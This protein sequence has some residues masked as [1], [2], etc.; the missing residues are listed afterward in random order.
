MTNLNF[1]SQNRGSLAA[2]QSNDVGYDCRLTVVRPSFDCRSTLLKLV[3]VLVLVLTVGVGQMLGT[4]VSDSYTFAGSS[5]TG[6]SCSPRSTYCGLY[7]SGGKSNDFA[8]YNNSIANISGVDFSAVS[9]ASITIRVKGITNGGTNSFT[10]S[11]VNSSGTA[12]VTSSAQT[13]QFANSSNSSSATWS[14]NV[15]LTPVAGVTGYKINCKAKS[16]LAG[17]DYSLTYTAAV[18]SAPTVG[19]AL[20]SVSATTNSITATVPISATGGCNIT[21]NGL[22]YSSSN[23]TPTVGGTNCTKVTTTACGAT[24][25][26]KE[27]TITGLTCGT[28]YNI[29]GYATNSSGTTY[30][31]VLTQVTS[32]CPL[33]TVTLMDDSDTRT[34]G[35]YGAAVTLPSRAGCE[36]Y[37]FAGWTKSWVA[38]QTE[39]TATAPTVIP[40]GSYT[41]E[42]NENLYPVYTKTE[43]GSGFSSYTKVTSAPSD[44]SGKYLISDGTSTATGAQFSAS[45][46]EITTLTP[47]TTEYT[48]YEFTITKNGNNNNYYIISPD[49]TY[50]VGYN[51]STNLQFSTST[52]A[53]NSYLWTCQTSDPMTLN[54]ATNTRYIGVGTESSTSVFKAYSTSGSNAKCY[55]Y[56]RI[57]GGSTTYYK[58]VPNCCTALGQINGS[59]SWSNSGTSLTVKNWGYTPANTG[60]ES[61]IS[62]YTVYLYSDEDS[63]TDPI[64]G[65]GLDCTVANRASTGVTFTGLDYARTY[66]VKITVTP[67]DGYCPVDEAWSGTHMLTCATPTATASSFARATQKMPI[68]WTSGAEKVDICYSSNSYTPG[69]TPGEGYTTVSNQT[70]SP[71]NLDVSGLAAGNY[72]C[73]VRSVCDASNKSD[74]TAITG[75]TFTIPAHTLTI[76]KDG[77]GS[78]TITPASG[79]S[80]VE[81]RT[82]SIEA[83]PANGYAFD[84]WAVSGTN[85]S[86]SSTS[87]NPTTFT[88][89]TANATVTGYFTCVTPAFAENGHPVSKTDYLTTDVATALSYT[90]SAAGATLTQQWQVST[91]N[92]SW[93]DIAALSGGTAATYTPDISTEGTKYYRVIVTNSAAGCSS[94]TATSNVA[95][96]RSTAPSGYCISVYNSSNNGIQSGFSNGGLGNEYTLAF[97]VPGKDGSS[98]WPMFWIGENNSSQSYSNNDYLANM[99]FTH[100]NAT[101]G[102]AEGATGTLHIWD[103]NKEAGSNLWV[104]F[105]PD[106]YGLRWGGADW[107][108][109]ENTKA[110]TVDPG[111]ANVWWTDLVTLDG[112]NNTTWNYYVGLKT[113]SGYVYSGV[114]NEASDSRGLSRTRSVTAMKVSN[115]TSGSFKATYLDGESTGTR[116]KFRIWDN[117]IDDY[118]FVCHFV[119]FWQLQ[120]N[121]NGGEGNMSPLPATPVCCEASSGSR[122]VTVATSSFTAPQYKQFDHWN[123]AADNSGSNVNTGSYTLTGDVTLYAQWS[124]IP[125]T[126]LTL[127]NSSLTKYVGES[128]VTLSVTDVTPAAANPAVT[129]SSSDATVAEVTAGGVVSFLKA[130]TATI[131]A[132]STVSGGVTATC[133]VVVRS[134]SGPT[135]KDTDGTTISGSGLSATWTVGT[136]TL[137]AS[138]ETSNYKFKRWV[139]T[140]ATPASE[141]NATTTLGDPTGNVTVVA[142]FYKPITVAWKVGNGNASGS[143]TTEVK[144]G[145]AITALPN[146][147]ADD[148]IASCGANK[149]MGWTA[150]G[151]LEGTGHSAPADLFTTVGGATTLTTNTT[152]RAVFATQSSGGAAVNTVLWEEDFSAWGDGDVPDA[153][154]ITNSHTGT[155]VYGD[156]TLTYACV[157]GGS[158]TRLYGGNQ[159]LYAGGTKPELLV[160]KNTGSFTVSGIPNGGASEITVSYKQNNKSLTVSASGTGYSGDN[161]ANTTATQSFDVT[162]GSASTFTLTF[163][164]TQNE[165]ARLDDISVKVKTAG[166]SI[167]NYITGCCTHLDDLNGEVNW[168]NPTTAVVSWDNIGHVSSWTVKY[169]TH[170]AGAYT[171]WDGSQTVYTKS[172]SNDSRKVTITGLTPCVDY[173]FKIM[174][175]ADEDYCDKDQTIEDD[176]A[177]AYTVDYSGCSNVTKTGGGTTACGSSNLVATFTA[178]LPYELPTSVSVSIGGTPQTQGTD[179]T[180]S[181]AAGVGTLTIGS[182]KQTANI[183][184]DVDGNLLT[185]DVNPTI[186]TATLDGSGTFNLSSVAVSV[187]GCDVGSAVCAWA[188]YGFVWGTSANPTGNKTA[189]G[190]DGTATSWSG[191]LTGSFSTGVTYYYRAYG[192]NSKDGAAIVYGSDATF[193]PRSVTFNVNGGS[194]VAAKYVNNGGTVSAPSDP[195]KNGYT[196]GGWYTDNGTWASPVNWSSTISANVTYY[197]KWNT[198]PYTITYDG[199]SGASNTNPTEYNIETPTI[200]LADPG[201]RTGYTFDRWTC[202]GD[203]ITQI[204]QGSTGDKT[205]TANWSIHTPNLAVSAP[206][207]VA[208]TATPA[209]ELAIEEGANRNVNY[210]KTITLNC[211]PDDHWNLVWDVYKT[212]S[213]PKESISLTGS[214]DGATF[215]M[216]D[217]AVTVSAVMTEDTY[218]TA[219]FMNNA[220]VI[221]GYGAVKTYDG[222]RPTPP[223]L[224]DVTD[225]CDKTECNK[226]YG[227]IAEGDIWAKTIPSVAGKTIYRH[228]EDIPVVSG[229]NVVYHA[230][231]AKGSGDPDMPNTLIAKWDKQSIAASTAIK[232]KDKDGNTLN[233]VTMTSNVAMTTDGVYCY[234]N[235]S[236]STDPVITLAGLDFSDYNAG[237]I[238]FFMRGSQ[239]PLVTVDY[240]TNGGSTYTTDYFSEGTAK[241]EHGYVVTVPNTTTN[242][243]ISYGSNT[244]NLYFGTVRA[245]GT[246]TTSY[247]FTELTSSNTSGW[248]GAD[249]DGYYLIVG[250]SSTKALRSD[251]MEGLDGLT[252][253]SASEGVIS[254]SD[255]GLMFKAKYNSVTSK[256]AI[257]SVATQDYLTDAAG[258]ASDPFHL[259]KTSA[260]EVVSIAYNDILNAT[261]YYVRWNSD[262]FGSYGSCTAPTLYKIMGSFSEFRVTCCDKE[263]TIGTPTKTGSGTVTFESGGDAYDVGDKVETCEGETTITATVTPANGF[264]CTALGFSGGSVSVSPAIPE[265]FV[266]YTAATAYTL[267]FDQNTDATLATTVTFTALVDN[268]ID[269]MHYNAT[270]EKSGDYGTVPSLSSETKGEDVC[271]ESHYK[272]MGWVAEDEINADGSLKSGYTLISGGATGK[273]A[274]GTNYYAVW[275]E[276]AE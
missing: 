43:A 104:K 109:A 127:N 9:S 52:P 225:A 139:V 41:P 205:I 84:H 82:A 202:G 230:V 188:D 195:S 17:T 86:L 79:S 223:T 140:N 103:N 165:N 96:I 16:A 150:N 20:T 64:G 88:M 259:L 258:G 183:V 133:S 250:N 144:Y 262:R 261:G 145:T 275:A 177:H 137:T 78:S 176:Q 3:T 61:H 55:L 270:V 224:T 22:V 68:S 234:M 51:S 5:V 209:S 80:V 199:L 24:A 240:S 208:I 71:V 107:S 146:T 198:I 228:A 57:E 98:N 101:L 126:S 36:G 58:S 136:R 211:T 120:Y 31:N 131:T 29:R 91:D 49:G 189:I 113:A 214:G 70:S 45:A 236:I 272:F 166:T 62:K 167:S 75:N 115:G 179:F 274:T 161:T 271:S 153:D 182:A 184:I 72:Y 213:N 273:Y 40:A 12:L 168:S 134:V 23:A 14:S 25:A 108:Q 235:S 175:T 216:P 218:H 190:S 105:E 185:C 231:W 158:D 251:I 94:A 99:H 111:D 212:G 13:N 141:T 222:T 243:K 143:P 187:T 106:G 207:N 244:G 160:G 123:T 69:A 152:Y 232:A 90:A 102:L 163:A 10:V 138:D 6:W 35:S 227:W 67:S 37:T 124:Y 97:T 119:P 44:W 226:F 238:T 112:T 210:N 174:A 217:Y 39:W 257:Q 241:K 255:L 26:N 42:G 18:C 192:K 15:V 117:N 201:T 256:Y 164:A 253:V 264:Q 172:V 77:G 178:S 21:E 154:D 206:A 191:T 169:K 74:W 66:K 215:T 89:G 85:A 149:F 48:A 19:S 242:V 159:Q 220:E 170:D 266:P 95:T 156:A 30:T 59:V 181:V 203:A 81:G 245:Y 4:T 65:E 252:T 229:A 237:V 247:D 147:P 122:T 76:T 260:A 157:N 53:T 135:M 155:T 142:E 114:D 8:V 1:L 246:K 248:S 162:V 219:T 186:G 33:Y 38:T 197:A 116:G 132:T 7:Y 263:I 47:G 34:Q 110:F 233:S 239:T 276:E 221:D 28:T 265:P 125:V 180:W 11:L 27:V 151:K 87:T 173:D 50:Y 193:L 92:S 46:L 63:Y 83:T 121:C 54:V 130:G 204:V 129:W 200:T 32:A 148:A 196:F 171:T 194:D 100:S 118:N 269:R 93:D 254:T 267:T 56:K 128:T 73:W 60:D 249:W 2:F 268:Y